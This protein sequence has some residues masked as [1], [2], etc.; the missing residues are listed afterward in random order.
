MSN[1]ISIIMPMYNAEKYI[2]NAIRSVL[3]QTFIEWELIIVDDGSEDRS[4]TMARDYALADERIQYEK[5]ENQGVS[6][7]RN[8][9]I[10]IAQGECICFMD[11]DDELMPQM[12]QMMYACIEKEQADIVYCGMQHRYEDGTKENLVPIDGTD[13]IGL[14][15]FWRIFFPD[16]FNSS[17]YQCIG[18][19]LYRRKVLQGLSFQEQYSY[20]EDELFV[21]QAISHADRIGLVREPGYVYCHHQ[22]S[23]SNRQFIGDYDAARAFY[24]EAVKQ[25]DRA[26]QASAAK[27]QMNQFLQLCL[28]GELKKYSSQAGYNAQN[29][30]ELVQYPETKA[31]LD[32]RCH[33]GTSGKF[34]LFLIKAKQYRLL[35]RLLTLIK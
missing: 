19:K 28:L 6:H 4:S 31:A 24:R 15:D 20:H 11:S 12:L 5:I 32:E 9:G 16:L 35:Y 27:A 18:T 13:A 7:A 26:Q 8:I 34:V 23:L 14:S 30:E 21:T 10:N 29:I 2:D 25:I 3:N 17:L 1:K 22:E 33:T